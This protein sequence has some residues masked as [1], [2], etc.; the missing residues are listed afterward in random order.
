MKDYNTIAAFDVETTGKNPAADQIVEISI[1]TTTS[2]DLWG[3]LQAGV[4]DDF[5]ARLKPDVPVSPGAQAVHG[6]SDADLANEA[7]FKE[8]AD[9]IEG[10]LM[11]ADILMGY[12]VGFDIRFLEAEFQRIGRTLDLSSKLVVDPLRIW[13]TQEPR[14]LENAFERFVGGTFSDAHSALADTKAVMGVLCGMREE[15]DLHDSGW[16]ELAEMTSPDRRFWV[17]TSHHL[18]WE[19]GQVVLGFGKYE[20]RPLFEVGQLDADYLRWVRESNFPKHVQNLC[21]GAVSGIE[22]KAF[23]QKVADFFGEPEPETA[24]A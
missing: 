17:G 23:R 2:S 21:K 1:S 5:H 13:H 11:S 22:A 18:K 9:Q 19:A 12:N 16:D 20:G 4:T 7:S 3:A 15:F 24:P 8:L 10:L 6:I 14:K